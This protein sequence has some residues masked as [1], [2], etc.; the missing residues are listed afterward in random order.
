MRPS[1]SSARAGMML[2][3]VVALA[4][5]GEE[6]Y[7][8]VENETGGAGGSAGDAVSPDRVFDESDLS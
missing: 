3:A 7:T 8:P 2:A 5:C 1:G 4:A 6:F